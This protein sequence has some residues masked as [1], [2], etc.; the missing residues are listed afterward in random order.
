[1]TNIARWL[2]SLGLVEY[3]PRFAEEAID[4]ANLRDLTEHDLA[5]LGVKIGHRARIMRAIAALGA[6]GEALLLGPVVDAAERRQ[7]TL[8]FCDIADSTR[9]TATHDPEDWRDLMSAFHACVLRVIE[10]HGGVVAERR[11]D[12]A[13]SYFGYPRAHEDDAVQAIRAALAV[14]DSVAEL[15]T[16]AGAPLL[17]RVTVSTGMTIVGKHTGA[18]AAWEADLVGETANLTARLQ[19][20]AHPGEVVVCGRTQALAGEHFEYLD[21]GRHLLKGLTEPVVAWQVFG[22]SGRDGRLEASHRHYLAPLIGRDEELELLMR[23]WDHAVAG[24]GRVVVVLGEPGIGKSHL[25]GVLLHRLDLT[26]HAVHRMYCSEHH[27][28]ATLHPFISQLERD[29]GFTRTDTPT[30]RLHKL[31]ALFEGMIDDPQGALRFLADLLVLPLSGREDL[32]D[33]TPQRRKDRALGA[34]IARIE[35]IAADRPLLIVC[36]DLHWIDPTSLELLASLVERIPR[37][38]VSR[39]L[40]VVTARTEFAPPWPAH[41]HVTTLA[42]RRL[43]SS[44]GAAL[45]TRVAAGKALPEAVMRDILV[46]S[47]RVPLFIEEMTKAVLEGGHLTEL[48]DRYE[49]SIASHDIP[50]SLQTS[51]VARLDRLGPAKEIAQIG[52]VAG[53][54][55]KYELLRAVSGWQPDR[56]DEALRELVRSELVFRRGEPPQAL[57]QFKHVLVR[58][59]ATATLLRRHHAR[60]HAAVAK[61]LEQQLFE[62][63]AAQPETIADHYSQADLPDKAVP[64]WLEAGRSAARRG[65]NLEAV[66]HLRRGL[67]AVRG[68]SSSAQAQ[69]IELDLLLVLAP[70]LI[71]TQGPASSDSLE[72]FSRARVLC[73]GLANAP[74]YARVMFWFAT[75]RVVRGE[76]NEALEITSAVW[77]VAQAHDDQP[78]LLNAVR[79]RGMIQ[80]F[81]GRLPEAYESMR[82]ALDL[83]DQADEA[84]RLAARSAGQDAGAAGLALMSWVLWLRGDVDLSVA[85]VSRALERARETAHPHTE[86]Y[87]SYYAAVLHALRD[88]PAIAN[89]HAQRCLALSEE[90]GFRQWMGLSRAILAIC[91]NSGDKAV[92]HAHDGVDRA[93]DDYR[94]AGYQLGT[95]VLCA[96]LC[97]ALPLETGSEAGLEAI[98]RGLAI[99]ERTR[100]CVFESELYRLKARAF[101]GSTRPDA[102]TQRRESLERAL[103]VARAQGALSF[104]LRVAVDLARYSVEQGLTEDARALLPAV[105]NK[106]TE[107][108]DGVEARAA[109]ALLKTL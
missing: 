5:E 23:R 68:M 104:E 44:D 58:E 27:R 32:I 17:T 42:V 26:G 1:M 24:E 8:L 53:R 43:N 15:R 45:I 37:S 82:S 95:T 39:L 67:D 98:N 101:E 80:L 12:G 93:L 55:F 73:D 74:E 102:V 18:D 96:L 106:L 11:G 6:P 2:D 7:L 88:E 3:G 83:F 85:F 56:L 9:L 34:L 4:I 72:A 89:M 75:A 64:F 108:A 49:G 97:R 46:R 103:T 48:E 78:V 90:H 36:E 62:T 60:L 59:A 35:A 99:V 79:G 69:R 22:P 33:Q 50:S 28:H 57:Y 61:A 109:K 63:I 40:L 41:E 38:S 76:L 87:A 47:E 16:S 52:A 29:A 92:A 77:R 19:T 51:L 66:A 21:L 91:A 14:R 13:F 54:E 81:M 65:A 71:A 30:E 105:L 31:T 107:G 10:S 84:T 86:A 25:V 20:L 94:S 100:E 70:C